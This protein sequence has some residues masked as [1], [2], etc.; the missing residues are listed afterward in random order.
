L[1]R[2]SAPYA[3]DAWVEFNQYGVITKQKGVTAVTDLRSSL[4]IGYYKIYFSTAFPDTS[5]FGF[6]ADT[7]NSMD[8]GSVGADIIRLMD[9]EY[10]GL[11]STTSCTICFVMVD[12]GAAQPPNLGRVY[13]YK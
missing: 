13:F 9:S 6:G 4:D 2:L 8:G 12:N 1:N 10:Y 7:R 11:K 3:A 5:Y